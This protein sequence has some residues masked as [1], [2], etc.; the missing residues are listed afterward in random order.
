VLFTVKQQESAKR[1]LFIMWF[2]NFFIGGSMTMVMPF[3]S[4]Y[5]ESFGNFSEKYVQHW[6]G[7]TFGIT[8]VSAFIFSPIWGKIGDRYGRKK[9]LIFSGLGMALSIFLMGFVHSVLQL[10]ILRFFMGFFS[11]FV[12]MSQAFI[13]TQTPRKIAGRVLGTLQ[14]GSITG[15]LLGPLLGGILADSLGYSTTFKWT[16]ISIFISALLVIATKEYRIEVK[17]GTK[18]HYSSKEVFSHIVRNPVLLT[19]LLISALVQIAHFSIQPILSLFVSDLHGKTNVAFYSGIAFSAAGLGNL[20]MSR[21]WGKFADRYGYIKILIILLFL[22]GI[23]YLPGAAVTSLW[24]LV[25]IRFALGITIGGIIPV[26]IAYI[27]QEAPIA[28]QGEVL[29]YNTSLRFFGNIIGPMLG[30]FVS[31]YYGFSAVFLS[32]SA[33]LIISGFILLLSMLRNPKLVKYTA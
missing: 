28:M 5:I 15:S 31:G 6:S 17:K 2:A 9:I 16:S 8:F 18:S 20:L 22:A 11:G 10:F 3:I 29:G 21:S 14:T 4:L 26:R 1:N 12:S 33:L 19:V 24:Q 7:I 13:S 23:V 30:G 27:R 32:T 25:I